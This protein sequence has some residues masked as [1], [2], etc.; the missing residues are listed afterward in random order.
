MAKIVFAS[1]NEHKIKEFSKMFNDTVISLQDIGFEGDIEEKGE[2]FFENAFIKAKTIHDFLKSKNLNYVVIADDSGLC[3]NA[4]G[5]EPGAYSARYHQDHNPKANRKKLLEE[6][7][8]KEDRSAY[9]ECCLV[10]YYPDGTYVSSVGRSEGYI[11]EE[12]EGDTSFG[13]DCIF[14]SNELN[15]SFG[16]ASSEEK[17]RVSHRGRAVSNLLNL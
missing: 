7:K 13:Y 16:V 11:L 6:L 4:L 8:N 2:T 17:N 3:V 5:G 14:F 9:F 12:E 1:N 15:K 10:K